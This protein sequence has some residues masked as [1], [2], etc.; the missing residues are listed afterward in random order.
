VDEG[1][2]RRA[3]EWAEWFA[4]FPYVGQ[5]HRYIADVLAGRIVACKWVKA[6]CARQVDDLDRALQADED[7]EQGDAPRWPFRFDHDEAE[8][9]LRGAQLFPH[10]KGAKAGTL[11]ALEPWQMFGPACVFG[12]VERQTNLRRYRVVYEEVAR[13]NAKTTRGATLLLQML[14]MDGEGGAECYTAATTRDQARISFGV[15]QSMARLTMGFR[16]RFGVEVLARA[17]AVPDT[18]SVCTPLSRDSSS[19]D[20]LNVHFA[21]IDELH[22]HKSRDLYDVIDSGTGARL[23]PLIWAIT[24]AGSNRSGICYERRTH[25]TQVLNATLRRHE[26]MGYKLEGNAIDDDRVWGM[27][28]T[29]DAEDDPL[30]PAVWIKANPNLGVSVELD[31]MQRMATFARAVPSAKNNFLTKR[32][33]VW[34][35]ADQ[36]WMDMRKWDQCADPDLKIEEFLGERCWVGIDAAFKTDVFAVSA[37]FERGGVVYGFKFYFMPSSKTQAEGNGHFAGWVEQG[38]IHE[39][40]GEVVDMTPVRDLVRDLTARFDVQS[41]GYDPA[42][43]TQ[44]ATECLEENLPMVECRPLVMNFSPA[45]KEL[46]A[47][48]MSATYRHTGCPVMGWMVAN[49]V[50]HRDA[51]DNIYPRK[52]KPENKIDGVIAECIA[53]SRWLLQE[54]QGS[55]GFV[56][57]N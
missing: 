21:L 3:E 44:F 9:W 14:T 19:L 5:A 52:E 32:L 6:A 46:E 13:K 20:G 33:N 38:L 25:L 41:I 51:K 55:P 18:N 1:L 50:C 35:N 48:V 22:A 37:N 49:V 53:L 7:I 10:V 47:R 4:A 16:A 57:L 15:A 54:P 29:I 30:D 36:A 27:I 12:W 11:I 42:Q 2:V 39:C 45:M 34:V 24:T 28:Y 56:S 26:G 31:D 8:R 40:P 23:Q 17:I 43:I